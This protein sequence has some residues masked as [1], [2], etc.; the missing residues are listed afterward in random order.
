VYSKDQERTITRGYAVRA[1]TIRILTPLFIVTLLSC[2]LKHNEGAFKYFQLGQSSL[3]RNIVYSD[4]KGLYNMIIEMKAGTSS[5]NMESIP[6]TPGEYEQYILEISK[7]NQFLATHESIELEISGRELK[8]FQRI[9]DQTECLIFCSDYYEGIAF[10]IWYFGKCNISTGLKPILASI[11]YHFTKE[12]VDKARNDFLS[13]M[14]VIENM[15]IPI[16]EKA[17]NLKSEFS[18]VGL[19]KRI[20]YSVEIEP[21]SLET[22]DFYKQF[23]AANGWKPYHSEREGNWFEN[24]LFFTWVDKTGEMLSRLVILSERNTKDVRLAPQSILID[25]MPFRILEWGKVEAKAE[26]ALPFLF[27]PFGNRQLRDQLTIVE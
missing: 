12:T 10:F 25:V 3:I 18:L 2:S 5:I 1:R 24:R 8:G 17:S 14:N 20:T 23:F 13:I 7:A 11:K 9:I 22:L 26:M 16:Y 19:N 21:H 15:N 4:K 27:I 6:F